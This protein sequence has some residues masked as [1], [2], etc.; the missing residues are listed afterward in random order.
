ME[1]LVF[2]YKLKLEILILIGVL[3]LILVGHTI[4]GTCNVPKIIEGYK[5]KSTKNI[6]IPNNKPKSTS[7]VGP[8]VATTSVAAL[9]VA[10][11]SIETT[12]V[13]TPSVETTSVP[14][15]SVASSSVAAPS[16]ATTS[17]GAVD[18]A[19]ARESEE[20]KAASD[21]AFLEK[22]FTIANVPLEHRAREEPFL[23]RIPINEREAF[24]KMIIENKARQD[25]RDAHDK[26]QKARE[27]ENASG[28]AKN[29]VEHAAFMTEVS[30]I[31]G[32][33][34]DHPD[35]VQ[36]ENRNR[37]L[38]PDQR[39][40]L[41]TA[42][43]K[44]KTQKEAWKVRVESDYRARLEKLSPAERE[45]T[46]KKMINEEGNPDR[47]AILNSILA[48]YTKK[49]GFTGA[50][51]SSWSAQNMTL[52]Q[53]HSLPEGEMFM[54]ANTKFAPECCPGTYS[55]SDGCECL[56]TNKFSFF[57]LRGNNLPYSEY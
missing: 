10:T 11:P 9:S 14:A 56:T 29:E 57:K 27:A 55:N 39:E 7:V 16:V 8:S 12:S 34:P 26:V 45:A 52:I 20:D 24:I 41:L 40:K 51:T 47:L 1:I 35:M 36:F 49:E 17:A 25:E 23:L 19:L 46:L 5:L 31:M 44:E 4:C 3:C 2:G 38:T 42:L 43:A 28:L 15:P 22:V 37:H 6:K 21:A 32:M 48:S 50:N 18:T 30:K 13:A 33:P 53:G 54:F